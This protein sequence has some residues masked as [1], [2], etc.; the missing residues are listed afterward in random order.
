M[1]VTD[2]ILEDH[3]CSDLE[4]SVFLSLENGVLVKHCFSYVT[5][6]QSPTTVSGIKYK[7]VSAFYNSASLNQISSLKVNCCKMLHSLI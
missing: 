7:L 1:K 2:K 3:V 5:Y 4:R 6:H